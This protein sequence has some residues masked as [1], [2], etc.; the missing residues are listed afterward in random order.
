MHDQKPLTPQE[1][2]VLDKAIAELEADPFRCGTPF[3]IDRDERRKEAERKGQS[4][5]KLTELWNKMI[6]ELDGDNDGHKN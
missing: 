5:Y 2:A 1:Q 4:P 6:A 3:F